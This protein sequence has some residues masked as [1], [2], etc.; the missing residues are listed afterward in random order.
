MFNDDINSTLTIV[1][2]L[3]FFYIKDK[4]RKNSIKLRLSCVDHSKKP[5]S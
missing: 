3:F 2:S 5:P 1:L 4:R